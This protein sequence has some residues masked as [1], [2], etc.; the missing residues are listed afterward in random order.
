ME[1]CN[2]P[3]YEVINTIANHSEKLFMTIDT[4]QNVINESEN[5][6]SI[7]ATP[8]I[9]QNINDLYLCNIATPQSKI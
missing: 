5:G 6:N 8:N 4:W 3:I 9:N 2:G 1:E 7:A